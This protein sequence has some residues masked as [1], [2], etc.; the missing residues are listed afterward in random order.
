MFLKD[1]RVPSQSD[2][3]SYRKNA[4]I[5][6][7][8]AKSLRILSILSYSYLISC[9]NIVYGALPLDITICLKEYLS[10]NNNKPGPYFLPCYQL[11]SLYIFLKG[12]KFLSYGLT[13]FSRKMYF[14]SASIQYEMIFYIH[15][16]I[17]YF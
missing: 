1:I 14:L 6:A 4:F 8:P 7:R 5:Y 3:V 12:K 13:F 16:F 15:L 2:R 11:K 17:Y 10:K 9:G